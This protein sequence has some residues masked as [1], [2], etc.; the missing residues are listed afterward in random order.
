MYM[1][2]CTC[3]S[4][5]HRH[6]RVCPYARSVYSTSVS[7]MHYMCS[8]PSVPAA[9]ALL[10]GMAE[11]LGPN[12]KDLDEVYTCSLHVVYIVNPYVQYS[13]QI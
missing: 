7:Y 9:L 3:K 4:I 8:R 13:W 1:Y 10:D 6:I 11:V 5:A 12:V 2:V